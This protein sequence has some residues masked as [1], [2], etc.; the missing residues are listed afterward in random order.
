MQSEDPF[1]IVAAFAIAQFWIAPILALAISGIYFFTSP[2]AQALSRRLVASLHGAVIAALYLGALMFNA[3]GISKPGYGIPFLA[4][5]LLPVALIAL[6]FVLY[7]GRR[8]LHALQ[9]V[10]LLCMTW[11]FFIGGMAITGEWL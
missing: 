5:S 3:A 4:T 9:M 2:A 6:S 8:S 10:N 7:E 1:I 11:T